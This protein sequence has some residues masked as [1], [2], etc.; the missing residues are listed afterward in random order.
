MAKKQHFLI[1]DTETTLRGKVADFGAVVVDRK[2]QIKTQCAVLVAGVYTD[3]EKQPL[4]YDTVSGASLWSK[5]NLANRYAEYD[6]MLTTGVRMLASVSAINVWLAKAQAMYSPVLTAYNLPFDVDKCRKTGIN[7]NDF[8]ERFCLWAA[9]ISAYGRTKNYKKFIL[10]S[11]SFNAPTEKGN[12]TYKTNAE[13]MTRFCL[14]MPE[15]VDEPHQAIEDVI[16]YELPILQ[17]LLRS[18]TKNQ[19]IEMAVTYNW[20]DYQVKNNFKA[21]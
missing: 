20:R 19:I 7:L 13:V 5:E 18:Y 2:G 14:N 1:V 16:G 8:S 10:E 3:R 15:L 17:K 21:S 12:M 11:H 9:A 4:F 6:R